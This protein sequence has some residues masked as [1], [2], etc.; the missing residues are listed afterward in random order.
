M[1]K[2]KFYICLAIVLAE[3]LCSAIVFVAKLKFYISLAIVLVAK[4]K[5]YA[6]Q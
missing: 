4:L 2:L 5:F 6:W 1:A 3:V